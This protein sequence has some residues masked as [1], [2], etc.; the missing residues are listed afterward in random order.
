MS[1]RTIG[2]VDSA[3]EDALEI[4]AEES[5][6]KLCSEAGDTPA[7]TEEPDCAS[8]PPTQ[9]YNPV[10]EEQAGDSTTS[11]EV[12]AQEDPLPAAA[13]ADE[14]GEAPPIEQ[15]E[16]S[17]DTSKVQETEETCPADGPKTEAPI[18]PDDASSTGTGAD[19]QEAA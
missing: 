4:N 1:K 17:I 14:K 19:A 10:L 12:A 6:K 11:A 5:N 7:T 2:E 8:L 18:G 9:P 16:T 3:Q 15:Q 13:S